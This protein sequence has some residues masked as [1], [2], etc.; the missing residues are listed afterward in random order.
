[1]KKSCVFFWLIAT[2]LSI[3]SVG[4]YSQNSYM[5]RSVWGNGGM[6]GISNS[7]DV[8]IN[9]LSGQF[10][11]EYLVNSVPSATNYNLNQGFWVPV[12]K[13]ET[14]IEEPAVSN[15]RDLWNYPNPVKSSTSI[16][17]NLSSGGYISINVYDL[18]GNEVKS[19]VNAYHPAGKYTIVWD[20]KNENG[21][22]V[23]AGSY[24]YEMQ[25]NTNEITG[26]TASNNY[27][28]RNIMIIAR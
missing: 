26:A 4:T 13:Q 10:A 15:N 14:G 22:Q 27:I 19:I 2:I 12:P 9:I 8:K 3:V 20:T 7:N 6:V 17:Y 18:L 11:I 24:L 25:V 23:G 16:E 21:L 28:L 1:M 5:K